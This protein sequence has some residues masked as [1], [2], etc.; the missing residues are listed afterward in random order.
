ME[1]TTH[2]TIDNNEYIYVGYIDGEYAG[3]VIGIEIDRE[4]ID[5]RYSCLEKIFRGKTAPRAFREIIKAV[6][7][8]YKKIVSRIRNDNNV[9]LRIAL[10]EDFRIIGTT[11]RDGVIAVE[12]MKTRED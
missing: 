2:K 7:K 5:L 9:S 8:D 11:T 6:Q 3:G 4:T 10:S 1:Y 12:L